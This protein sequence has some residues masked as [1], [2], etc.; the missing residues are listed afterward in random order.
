MMAPTAVPHANALV[1]RSYFDGVEGSIARE[2][3]A[4]ERGWVGLVLF[5]DLA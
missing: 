4:G 2:Q 1:G 3:V 5:K